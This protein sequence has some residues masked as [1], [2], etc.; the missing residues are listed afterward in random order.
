MKNEA[1]KKTMQERTEENIII[2]FENE[3]EMPAEAEEGYIPDSRLIEIAASVCQKSLEIHSIGGLCK[4]SLMVVDSRTIRE[5]NNSQ[6]GIDSVTDVL[7]FPNIPFTTENKGD[8]SIFDEL[9]KADYIDP[10][11][12]RIVLGEI[13]ICYERVISQAKDYGHSYERELA[14]LTAHSILH[15]LGYD[16]IEESDRIEMEAMQRNILDPLGFKR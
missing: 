13:V 12:G 14:F 6:R 10:E 16:H 1:E 2:E 15:L 5:Y 11:D 8:V 4:V 3:T 9:N 7:S